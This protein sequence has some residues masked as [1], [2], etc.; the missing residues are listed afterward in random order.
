MR[1]LFGNL[2]IFKTQK[3]PKRWIPLKKA[4]MLYLTDRKPTCFLNIAHSLERYKIALYTCKYFRQA[5]NRPDHQIHF[6]IYLIVYFPWKGQHH[7]YQLQRQWETLHKYRFGFFSNLS[8]DTMQTEH[9][10]SSRQQDHRLNKQR[11]PKSYPLSLCQHKYGDL[12]ASLLLNYFSPC[13]QRDSL[14]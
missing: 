11:S 10:R 4:V 8:V 6:N 3:R 9:R 5:Y 2:K 14:T 7:V 12:S 13:I 1:P